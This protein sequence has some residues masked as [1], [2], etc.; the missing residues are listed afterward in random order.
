MK[1]KK[2]LIIVIS[3]ASALIIACIAACGVLISKV[4]KKDD[5][6]EGK[7]QNSSSTSVS[8][9]E[10]GKQDEKPNDDDEKTEQKE[11][12][13]EQ[14]KYNKVIKTY[15]YSDNY[16]DY[17]PIKDIYK[18]TYCNK[19]LPYTL[20]L[21]RDYDENK[22]YPVLLFLHGAGDRGGDNVA[23][24]KCINPAFYTSCDILSQ[25]IIICP[26]VPQGGWWDIY[27]GSEAKGYLVAAKRLCDL[28]VS[29][30]NGDTDRIYVTGLSMGGYGTWQMIDYYGDYFAAAAPLCGWGNT[31]AANRLKDIPIWIFHGTEDT[32]VGIYSSQVMYDAIKGCG[33][34]KISFTKAEG[35]GH[36]VWDV[37]YTDRDLFCWMFSQNKKTHQSTK[38]EHKALF[39]VKSPKG[40]VIFDE[41]G[42][43]AAFMDSEIGP[44]DLILTDSATSAL[45][46]AYKKYNNKNFSVYYCG[47]KVY[48]YNVV[49]VP[50]HNEFYIEKV[51]D[52]NN[53][54][55]LQRALSI[56]E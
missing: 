18:D 54:K 53:T 22:E 24:L 25:A 35:I 4:A 33:G 15:S 14:T 1:N 16:F 55:A 7:N 8:Q 37:A 44:I 3:I 30:Y 38:Y 13:V 45:K 50:E 6:N 27:D 19:L 31:S 21:P 43:E 42:V 39:E 36:N 29:R 49:T 34:D 56:V 32:T 2:V 52:D 17:N 5:K 40:E 20:F 10:S 26:Q 41:S 47:K 46:K 48:D 28:M 11:E 9:E 51:L 23:Q 12:K